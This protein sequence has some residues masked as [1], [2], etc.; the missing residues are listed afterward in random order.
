MNPRG[1]AVASDVKGRLSTHESVG[2]K[3]H[4]AGSAECTE[5]CELTIQSFGF[6]DEVDGYEIVAPSQRQYGWSSKAGEDLG[7]AVDLRWRQ[8]K[9]QVAVAAGIECSVES[10]QE[11]V[12]TGAGHDELGFTPCEFGQDSHSIAREAPPRVSEVDNGIGESRCADT[13]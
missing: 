11:F 12:N 7:E 10:E 13:F 2:R 4:D 6:H 1:G 8:V 9:H 3:S 5:L